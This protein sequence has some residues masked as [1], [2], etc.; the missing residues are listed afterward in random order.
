MEEKND[1]NNLL[2]RG[3]SL[4]VTGLPVTAVNIPILAL[5]SIYIE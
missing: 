2:N 1:N 4:F 5:F 3:C